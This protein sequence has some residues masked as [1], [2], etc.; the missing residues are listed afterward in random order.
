[1]GMSYLEAIKEKFNYVESGFEDDFSYEMTP[2]Y[3]S[4]SPPPPIIAAKPESDIRAEVKNNNNE[5]LKQERNCVI[6]MDNL[7]NIVF[8][9]CSHLGKLCY[10]S[11]FKI[12]IFLIILKFHVLNVVFLLNLVQY[13]EKMLKLH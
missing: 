7:K 2:Y 3:N 12:L 8:L 1:M 4:V 10:S 9:P 13:V 5:N 6:C 11:L